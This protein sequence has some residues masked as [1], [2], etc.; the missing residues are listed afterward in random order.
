MTDLTGY[1]DE[2]LPPDLFGPVEPPPMPDPV[3]TGANRD[4]TPAGTGLGQ[5]QFTGTGFF[6]FADATIEGPGAPEIRGVSVVGG[7][8]ATVSLI[9]P[10][11]GT[12]MVTIVNDEEHVSNAWP[13]EATLYDPGLS[14]VAPNVGAIGEPVT[15]ECTGSWFQPV[16]T[17][18][19]SFGVPVTTEYVDHGKVRGTF[20]PTAAGTGT[21]WVDN[22]GQT[23]AT[24]PFTVI[25]PSAPP[26]VTSF[27]NN[28]YPPVVGEGVL[29]VGGSN[30]AGDAVVLVDGV[31]VPTEFVSTGHLNGTV[32]W[33]SGT[34]T[35]GAR[36]V[37]AGLE[38]TYGQSLVIP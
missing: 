30:F 36:N 14:A 24:L 18:Q 7:R 23:S 11:L 8:L 25:D 34:H 9:A 4:W 3:I 15:V 37:S 12:Y 21:V 19:T 20:T 10:E 5:I 27:S 35:I 32:T 28:P 29:S 33:T 16:T 26:D 31:A 17:V 1:Y 13:I 2:S 38:D 6:F 22:E